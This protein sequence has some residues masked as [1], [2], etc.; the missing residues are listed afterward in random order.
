MSALIEQNPSLNLADNA[1][2]EQA[3][4]AGVEVYKG[5]RCFYYSNKIK[6]FDDGNN[7]ITEDINDEGGKT[8]T[9]TPGVMEFAIMRNN[10]YSLSIG[11]ISEIG[12][13]TVLPTPGTVVSDAG[14]YITMQ[15]RIL[16]WIVRFNN[17]NF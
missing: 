16:P 11:T 15:A 14:A 7:D 4:A 12:S 8:T 13:A 5:G 3:E 9:F 17:I 6:H 2:D 1:T 10:I